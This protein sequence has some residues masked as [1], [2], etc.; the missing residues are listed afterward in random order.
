MLLEQRLTR[1]LRGGT[2]TVEVKSGASVFL[3][4]CSC[5]RSVTFAVL[6]SRAGYGLEVE[7][8][9]KMLRV[10]HKTNAVHAIDIV[11]TYCGAHSIPVGKTADEA[12]ADVIEVQLPELVVRDS[13][14]CTLPVS[15]LLSPVSCLRAPHPHCVPS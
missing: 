12:T 11:S 7:T 9:M 4:P 1:M 3:C 6:V 10:I 14:E 13:P 15:C 5:L 8:E 2:T